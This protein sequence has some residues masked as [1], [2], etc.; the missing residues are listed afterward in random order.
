MK[1]IKCVGFET[2]GEL[3]F[4][5]RDWASQLEAA[6]KGAEVK[7]GLSS[8]GVHEDIDV[9]ETAIQIVLRKI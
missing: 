1:D 5:L 7:N 8:D 2:L 6:L 9:H 4:V 3:I